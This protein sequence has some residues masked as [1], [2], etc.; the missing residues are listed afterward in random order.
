MREL[1][2]TPEPA[3]DRARTRRRILARGSD[4]P[5]GEI[6]SEPV[7]TP[8]LIR[9]RP[10]AVVSAKSRLVTNTV[11]VDVPTAMTAD[12]MRRTRP[13]THV[14]NLFGMLDPEA[15]P[16]PAPA[17]PTNVP[18]WLSC[19]R[20]SEP[21]IEIEIVS[22]ARREAHRTRRMTIIETELVEVQ[23]NR[24][25]GEMPIV[26]WVP[27]ISAAP[28]RAPKSASAGGTTA[29]MRNYRRG[30][31]MGATIATAIATSIVATAMMLFV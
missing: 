24:P 28:P 10:A 27:S 1:W 14:K 2:S 30:I 17:E 19:D 18:G 13:I 8:H 29:A 25:T 6:R 11:V 16:S 20:T 5:Q 21:E 7:A 4:S 15:D 9:A 3:E 26:N 22:W 23:N 12:S 31:V